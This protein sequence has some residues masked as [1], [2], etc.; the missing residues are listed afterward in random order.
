MYVP[1]YM[2]PRHCSST[3]YTLSL[4]LLVLYVFRHRNVTHF[5]LSYLVVTAEIIVAYSN[6]KYM[7][8]TLCPKKK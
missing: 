6:T 1:L 7:K 8:Y 5:T 4:T 2:Y 3:S